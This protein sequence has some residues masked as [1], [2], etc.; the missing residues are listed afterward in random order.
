MRQIT[1]YHKD[2]SKTTIDRAS[3]QPKES[4]ESSSGQGKEFHAH[5]L[6]CNKRAEADGALDKMSLR[7]RQWIKD[8]HTHAQQPGWWEN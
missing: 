5:F 2:G 4:Y 3:A 6:E 8:V 7:E 1:I